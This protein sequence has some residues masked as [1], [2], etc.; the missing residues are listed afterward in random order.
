MYMSVFMCMY[1]IIFSVTLIKDTALRRD[2]FENKK[3]KKACVCV[4]IQV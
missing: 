1:V 4:L 3:N 2:R